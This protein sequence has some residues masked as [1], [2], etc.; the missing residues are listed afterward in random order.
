MRHIAD[1]FWVASSCQIKISEYR[2]YSGVRTPHLAKNSSRTATQTPAGGDVVGL[3]PTIHLTERV[4]RYRLKCST[5]HWQC[6]W[7]MKPMQCDIG[8]R[9]GR[10]ARTRLDTFTKQVNQLTPMV[11]AQRAPLVQYT[12][13]HAQCDQQS[14]IVVG[15]VHTALATSAASSPGAV[16]TSRPLSLF[17]SHSPTV[18][19]TWRN[20]SRPD[21]RVWDKVPEGSSRLIFGDTVI[22]L[23]L[24]VG[25]LVYCALSIKTAVMG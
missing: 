19:A 17:I 22:S 14:A 13:L 6:M 9:L 7:M 4:A 23:K 8:Q 3:F 2:Y 10:R 20:V 24:S 1:H 15:C 25:N 18:G 5:E 11:L 16:N 21:T 12:E